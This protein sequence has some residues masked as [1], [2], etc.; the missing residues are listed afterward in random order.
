MRI[1][2]KEEVKKIYVNGL[3]QKEAQL[4][5]AKKDLEYYQNNEVPLFK[6]R[7]LTKYEIDLEIQKA[8]RI[9]DLN[10]YLFR[11]P[12]ALSGGQRQ[13]VALG[14]AIVRKPKV[15]LMDE[16]LSNLDAKLRVQT[17]A[18]IS[19]IHKRV[20]ATTIYVTHDQT[21]AMT[22]ADR[23]VVMKD[24]YIQQIGNPEE[25]YNNP[26]NI[27][28]AGFI[29][30][31]PMNFFNVHFDGKKLVFAGSEKEIKLTKEQAEKLVGFKSGEYDLVL[32]VRPESVYLKGDPKLEKES[33]LFE[34]VVDFRELLGHE[35][36]I[37]SDLNGQRLLVK[38]VDLIKVNSQDKLEV[39]VNNKD[40]YF[41]NKESTNRI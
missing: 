31:P 35:L 14:R 17:R 1:M 33:Q 15:F 18:E 30:N 34:A 26:N 41:F 27:F 39:G 9:L 40:L 7:K 5:S 23:I 24:G 36:V 10:T 20:G 38:L 19:K 8:A 6:N 13:R 25:I 16:P 32:G 21:E 2:N 4:E 22:M 3:A 12:A 29:G 11:K 28:V 37:Y